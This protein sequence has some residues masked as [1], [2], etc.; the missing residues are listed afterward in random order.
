MST[1]HTPLP[2]TPSVPACHPPVRSAELTLALAFV[3]AAGGPLLA[4]SAGDPP[5]PAASPAP[6]AASKANPQPQRVSRYVLID[7]DF[8]TRPVRTLM[9]IQGPADRPLLRIADADGV[10][11]D[12]P[13]ADAAAL[14]PTHWWTDDAVLVSPFAVQIIKT[15]RV[16]A[17][18]ADGFGPPDRPAGEAPVTSGPPPRLRAQLDPARSLLVLADGS[19]FAGV[20]FAPGPTPEALLWSGPEQQVATVPLDAVAAYYRLS[21]DF[22][23]T[24]PDATPGGSDSLTLLNGDRLEGFIAAIEPAGGAEPQKVEGKANDNASEQPAA[25]VAA[26]QPVSA[27]G[28]VVIETRSG[29]GARSKTSV[30]VDRVRRMTVGSTPKPLPPVAVWTADGSVIAGDAAADAAGLA[31]PGSTGVLIRSPLL[32]SRPISIPVTDL[33]ALTTGAVRVQPLASLQRSGADVIV[34]SPLAPLGASDVVIT[35]PAQADFVLPADLG[36]GVF[37]ATVILPEDARV[38]GDC[39]VKVEL[40]GPRPADTV[41]LASVSVDGSSPVARFTARLPAA[42]GSGARTLRL[43]VADGPA[44]RGPVQDV[45]VLRRAMIIADR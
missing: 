2:S 19:R 8:Q 40:L 17:A 39:T 30:L 12:L 22:A 1:V 23:S 21:T 10:P 27:A 3:L 41:T 7:R 35:G 26:A 16:G 9:G 28:K 31:I 6:A 44:G 5:K 45:V 42:G 13:L 36:P 37:G 34:G 15:A 29:E 33:I 43:V 32:P 11:A 38:W 20:W 24:A 25:P 14:V 18:A 4:Q